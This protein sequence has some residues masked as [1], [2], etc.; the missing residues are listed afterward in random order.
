MSQN[1]KKRGRMP[2][3]S[4]ALF[5]VAA[6]LLLGSTIGSAR[7]ALT[8]YSQ[9]YTS[10]V[11]MHSIGVTL[12]ENG[13]K[14]SWRDYSERSNGTWNET[15]GALLENMLAEGEKFQIG[16]VYKEEL[17]VTNTGSIDQYVRV[18]IYRY[19][20]DADGKKMQDL[21]PD[22][23]DL[24]L[25]NIGNGWVVDEKSTT[26][27]RTVLYYDRPLA[28]DATTLPFSDQIKVENGITAKVT[29]TE[30][31]NGKYT[32]IT[33]TY[34]YDGVKFQLEVEVNAVQTHNA[35]DAIWSAWGRRASVGADGTLRL[36]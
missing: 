17:A 21:S 14:V 31:K 24:N 30:E 13:E 15:T 9:T 12:L 22:L 7:A 10:R 19:W 16:K 6:L 2:V 35:E 18:N 23:I 27:E 32:T 20:L 29:Q 3:I 4:I 5:A 1:K 11:Q 25:V 33:T 36:N 8:Y 28:A 26:A 34:D